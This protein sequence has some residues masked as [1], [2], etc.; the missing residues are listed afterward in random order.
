[1]ARA[2]RPRAMLTPP[3]LRRGDCIG[4]A[5]PAGPVSDPQVL[6]R[7]VR[8]LES[9]GYT[10]AVGRHVLRTHGY[11]AGRDEDRTADLNMMLADRRIRAVIAL[12]GGYGS[13]RIL[14]RVDFA[15]ARRDPKI[16]AGYSDLTA[17]LLAFWTRCRLVTFHG[18]MLASDFGGAVDPFT[19]EHFWTILTSGRA[20]SFS[21]SLKTPE[22]RVLVGGRAEGR[23]L[24]GNL[25]LIVSLIGT[26]F[27]PVVTG[28]LLF[29]EEVGEEPYRIDRMLTQLRNAGVLRNAAGLLAGRFT[30]CVPVNR[31]RPSLTTEQVLADAA[32]AL[33]RPSL[34]GLPFGHVTS[35][36]TLPVGVR[37][38]MDA[39]RRTLVLLEPPVR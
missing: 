37:A 33:G 24:G 20:P 38:R 28:A 11:L 25:S 5:A 4:I 21:T 32:T 17:L 35:K 7:G 22:V 34:S 15:A 8:Y 13:T 19:E 36:L 3:R 29:L 10:V 12:R 18:P 39:G 27:A 9:L 14:P 6:D 2:V 30:D 23:L 26:P 16:I 31:K 1:M